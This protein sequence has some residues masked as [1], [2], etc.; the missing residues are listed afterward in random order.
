[1][2]DYTVITEMP[3]EMAS[4][5]QIQRMHNRYLWA[6]NYLPGKD[7]LEIACGAGQGLHY[8]S[9][10]ANRVAAGD[11][12][13]KL[14]EIAKKNAASSVEISQMNA[15]SLP[16]PNQ[17]FDVIV[18]FEAIYYLQNPEKFVQE[19]R[20]VLKPNG[21]LLIATANKDLYDFNPSPFSHRYFGVIELTQLLKP[22]GFSATFFGDTPLTTVSFKQKILRPLKKLA[23][24][25]NLMP[26]TK[27]GKSLF[28]RF[29]FGKQS[30]L[31]KAISNHSA[32]YIA[33]KLLSNQEPDYLHKVIFCEAR[34][35]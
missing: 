15:E 30:P 22:Y 13:D 26:K 2:I 9:S 17:S 6:S 35:T 27:K 10:I 19:C 11:I 3:G 14:V 32:P 7:V 24:S 21:Q 20:R 28:K 16:F 33:P 29:V 25:L 1:M 4:L 23:V 8:F 34:L 5:E 12:S 31:P 18:F